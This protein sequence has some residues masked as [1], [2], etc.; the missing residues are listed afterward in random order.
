MSSSTRRAKIC[1][2]IAPDG[3]AGGGMGRVKDYILQAGGDRD[4]RLLLAPLITR[5]NRGLLF[6]LYLTVRAVFVIWLARFSGRLALVHV[7]LGDKAAAIRKGLI[8]VLARLVG[9]KVV[10]HMHAVELDRHYST[11][12]PLLRFLIQRPFRAAS[13]NI[14]LGELWRRWLIDEVGV[15]PQCVEVLFNGVPIDMG[16]SRHFGNDSGP[17]QLLFLGNLMERKGTTD[18]IH[19]MALLPD[20]GRQVHLTLAG[21]GDIE[22]YR[23]LASDLGVGSSVS[24]V[25]WQ[26]QT[27][28]RALLASADCMILPSYDEGLPLVI[29]EALGSGAPVICTP[30]GA[31]PEALRDGE[32]A[33]FCRPG[34][35]KGI[36][37]R[38]L[39]LVNSPDVCQ[40]LSDAGRDAFTRRFSLLAFQKSLF[41]IYKKRCGVEIVPAS[42]NIA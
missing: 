13:C 19:A 33:L 30:V 14:V 1:Y 10:L 17:F 34:D 42:F 31:I 24:F 21:G 3:Q 28:T 25:G 6:S 35:Q 16:P 20:E 36:A 8:V 39:M 26:N 32:T 23:S 9:A 12:G 40:H 27:E 2:V 41:E 37:E 29:L 18:L 22:R 5:D 11:A 38:I 7:N 4:G 15:R